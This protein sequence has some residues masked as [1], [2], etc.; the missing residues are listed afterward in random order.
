[1]SI[2]DTHHGRTTVL[3]FGLTNISQGGLMASFAGVFLPNRHNQFVI[4]RLDILMQ[5]RTIAGIAHWTDLIT[6]EAGIRA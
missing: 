3:H 6:V 4:A 2:L 1:M 5:F